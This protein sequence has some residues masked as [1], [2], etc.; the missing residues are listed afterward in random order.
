MNSHH[1]LQHY[2]HGGKRRYR[3]PKC[4]AQN[5]RLFAVA[6]VLVDI[7]DQ[8]TSSYHFDHNLD[9]F[10][11]R[12]TDGWGFKPSAFVCEECDHESRS[13]H[14]KSDALTTALEWSEVKG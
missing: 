4:G 9:A 11:D 1:D 8:P 10:C 6:K 12:I 5:V 14:T 3:C 13:W 2:A 7:S